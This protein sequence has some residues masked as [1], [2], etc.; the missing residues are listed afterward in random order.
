[1]NLFLSYAKGPSEIGSSAASHFPF[2]ISE[3]KKPPSIAMKRRLPKTDYY[4]SLI[5]LALWTFLLTLKAH[6]HTHFV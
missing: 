3:L 4:D 5:S 6:E 1:M 2:P